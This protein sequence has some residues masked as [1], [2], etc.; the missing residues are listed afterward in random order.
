M[1]YRLQLKCLVSVTRGNSGA[2]KASRAWSR[3]ILYTTYVLV[4]VNLFTYLI[5]LNYFN[6]TNTTNL[7]SVNVLV[8][9]DEENIS[10]IT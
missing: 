5:V 7:L 10:T 4:D 1:S 8:A 3:G 2:L 6:T 9:E